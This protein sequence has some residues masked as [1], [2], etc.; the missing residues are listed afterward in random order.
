[1]AKIEDITCTFHMTTS[2]RYRESIN[3]YTG[4]T[5]LFSRDGMPSSTQ[6]IKLL[7]TSIH[8]VLPWRGI[9]FDEERP[10]SRRLERAQRSE[11]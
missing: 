10:L 8:L 2:T 9:P 6:I 4:K 5:Y 1:V 11:E 3:F 7:L